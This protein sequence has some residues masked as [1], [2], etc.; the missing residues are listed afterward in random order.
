MDVDI[1]NMGSLDFTNTSVQAQGT[2]R[3]CAATCQQPPSPAA[4][5][6]CLN[7]GRC[8]ADIMGGLGKPT[9]LFQVVQVYPHLAAVSI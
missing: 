2:C 7:H 8:D 9:L 3:F 6:S 1:Y 5:I 4:D